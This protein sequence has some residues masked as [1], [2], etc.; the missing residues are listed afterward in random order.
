MNLA[1]LPRVFEWLQHTYLA[2]TIRHSPTLIAALEIL[3]LIGLAMLLGTILMVNLSLLGW[4]IGDV[5][6]AGIARDL[7]KWTIA[8]LITMLASG[9]LLFM[10][11]AARCSKIPAFWI[12]MALLGGALIFQFTI[13]RRAVNAESV[14]EHPRRTAWVSLALWL[15]VVLAAKAIGFSETA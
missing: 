12:K 5:S 13:H 4:G 11:E 7:N 3:H 8:G 6:A 1:I 15:G 9:P 2:E 14:L 10:S